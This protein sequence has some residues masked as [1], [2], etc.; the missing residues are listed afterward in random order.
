VFVLVDA[1]RLLGGEA[2]GARVEDFAAILHDTPPA[3]PGVPVQ[4]PGERE[5]AAYRAGLRDG[6]DLPDDDVAA[7]RELGA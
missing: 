5:L 4:V 7:L 6:L 1:T 2:L 3:D